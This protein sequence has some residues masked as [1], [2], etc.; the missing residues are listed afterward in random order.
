MR[1]R[2]I[3]I[4]IA[5]V[6][7]LLAFIGAAVAPAVWVSAATT[8]QELNQALDKQEEIAKKM[9]ELENKHEQLAQSKDQLSGDLAWL[10]QRSEEQK[11]LYEEK[12]AQLQAALEEMDNAI[13][14]YAEAEQ[15]LA[16]KKEQY[17]Q[18]MQIMYEH[19]NKSLFSV[20][21]E[22]DSLHGF[23]TTLQLM[24]IIADTDEQMLDDLEIA[25]D[26]AEL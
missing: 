4:K 7:L 21:L 14:A 9:D 12:S 2:N 26:D 22:S 20:F 17:N 19:K 16:D 11:Q 3:L 10:N 5:A 6:L 18:R 24:S 15:V 23:F 25:R 1:G 8:S 13:S